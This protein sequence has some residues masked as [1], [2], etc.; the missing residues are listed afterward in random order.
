MQRAGK[1]DPA[2]AE[3]VRLF[4]QRTPE[5]LFDYQS[6]PDALKNLA[7]GSRPEGTPDR[8]CVSSLSNG[9]KKPRT[10]CSRPTA[11]I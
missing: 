1:K 4:L 3:R 6:D 9:W 10:R 8:K 7:A 2:I 5:E 11:S